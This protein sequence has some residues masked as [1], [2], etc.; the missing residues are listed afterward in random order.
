MYSLHEV[1]VR[2][3]DYAKH[4]QAVIIPPF[5]PTERPCQYRDILANSTTVSYK[6][7]MVSSG[8]YLFPKGHPRGSVKP[9]VDA[10][11][12]EESK[13]FSCAAEP[14]TDAPEKYFLSFP[15]VGTLGPAVT[16]PRDLSAEQTSR[17]LH[18]EVCPAVKLRD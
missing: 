10:E 13:G 9:I 4:I 6:P 14:W 17:K 11:I 15:R 7:R 16:H 2:L 1:N 3:V 18:V 5:S 8:L 12:R